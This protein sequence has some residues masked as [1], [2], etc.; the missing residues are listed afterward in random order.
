MTQE[1]WTEPTVL[2]FRH[3]QEDQLKQT[4]DLDRHLILSPISQV[5]DVFLDEAGYVG[6]TFGNGP[7]TYKLT[8][9]AMFQLCQLTCPSLYGL[10]TDLSGVHRTKDSNRDDYSFSDALYILNRTV[11]RRFHTH[12][13]GKVALVDMARRTIDGFVSASYRWLPNY[14]LYDRTKDIMNQIDDTAFFEAMVVGRWFM[15]RY[16]HK[17]PHLSI[18]NGEGISDPFY[19]GY[20]FSNNEVGKAAVKAASMLYR[21]FSKSAS[22]S[23]VTPKNDGLR[24]AGLKFE[25]RF[26]EAHQGAVGK[27]D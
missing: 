6:L 12:L 24:H 10:V 3:D 7:K 18:D 25:V 16:I 2:H 15:I 13:Q 14:E 9:W 27:A 19:A 4:L 22:I 20:H 21:K 1:L 5:Q 8:R 17:K 11:R 23:P 26:G